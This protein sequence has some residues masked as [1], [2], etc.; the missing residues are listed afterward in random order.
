MADI[1]PNRVLVFGHFISIVRHQRGRL[2]SCYSVSQSSVAGII[3]QFKKQNHYHENKKESVDE[4]EKPLR[5]M[6]HTFYERVN[7]T[8]EKQV[9]IFKKIYL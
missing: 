8:L 7:R 9:V 5:K 1:S 6:M 2:P 3:K 4:N